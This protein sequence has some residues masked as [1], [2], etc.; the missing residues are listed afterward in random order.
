MIDSGLTYKGVK[1]YW[2]EPA[3]QTSTVKLYWMESMGKAE[4]TV[5]GYLVEQVEIV[6]GMCDKVRCES[7]RGFPDYIV[8]WP[9]GVMTKV[10][11]KSKGGKC[12]VTQDLYHRRSVKRRCLVVVLHTRELVD[13]FIHIYRINWEGYRV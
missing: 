5:A 7:E 11:T 10:E 9:S 8:T 1:I 12:S 13:Q 3:E 6:G 2:D 4:N